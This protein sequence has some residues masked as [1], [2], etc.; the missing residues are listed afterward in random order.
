MPKFVTQTWVPSE[1]TASGAMPTA[2]VWSKAPVEA[3]SSVTVLSS[4]F[5]TQ[6]SVP[7]EETQRDARAHVDGLDDGSGRGVRL[8]DRVVAGVRQPDIGAVR[9]DG[10]GKVA[11]ADGL[12]DRPSRGVQ[13]GDRVA[14]FIDHPDVGVTD[15]MAS[16]PLPTP[17]VWTTA[18]VEACSSVTG[19]LLPRHG[20][21]RGDA[22][23]SDTHR[24][25]LDNLC[26]NDDRARRVS[27]SVPLLAPHKVARFEGAS[28]PT[29]AGRRTTQ[30]H[31]PR[32]PCSL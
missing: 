2:M 23:G 26:S 9:G 25:R 27:S 18:P 4:S 6:T 22:M 8:G 11:H 16:G 13:L 1:E 29:S 32:S 30:C 7:S 10:V 17:M 5:V 3:S 24:N 14:A 12:D 20:A 21:I 31:Y 19:C 28:T 15:G